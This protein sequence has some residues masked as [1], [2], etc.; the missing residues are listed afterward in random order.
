MT[1]QPRNLRQI[2]QKR[3]ERGM[4]FQDSG[5]LKEALKV[6]KW[7]LTQDPGD[8]DVL[9]NAGV[10][11]GQLEPNGPGYFKAAEYL[12]KVVYSKRSSPEKKA[13][14]LNQLG[15]FADRV[16]RPD[17]ALPAYQMAVGICPHHVP[18]RNNYASQL[19][20]ENR[21]QEAQAEFDKALAI[22]PDSADAR[23]NSAFLALTTGQYERG[24][25]EFAWR[26]K[27]PSHTS[28]PFKSMTGKP[29]W[30]GEDLNGKTL[31]VI[32]EQGFGDTFMMVRFLRVIKERW[33]GCR[34]EFFGSPALE[35]VLVC[36]CPYLDGYITKGT[37]ES[38]DCWAHT[39]TLPAC[40]GTTYETVPSEVPY[41][42]HLSNVFDGHITKEGLRI[43]IAWAGSPKHGR[44][45]LRSLA[46][47][48][49]QP[50]VDS[51]PDAHWY[52][53][54]VGPR[55]DEVSRLRGV[56]D[57]APSIGDWVN[58][59]G[60]LSQLDLLISCDTGTV[61]LAGAMGLPV[62]MLCPHSADWR[63]GMDGETSVWYPRLTIFRQPQRH[64]W[65]T[66]VNQVIERLKGWAP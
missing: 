37:E 6:W 51:R 11:V 48:D 44:D 43:G 66:P 58:T 3:L 21:I 54:Q 9:F 34:I 12:E 23:L 5:N 45:A 41:L 1:V 40:L 60:A 30:Q 19:R 8:P 62:F 33:P 14:A 38:F 36:G 22:D 15:I 53:L 35:K 47:E 42:L 55:C 56:T 59:A 65:K 29:E 50:I 2:H 39:F 26:W 18:A 57:L 13:D 31:L 32:E 28:K 24:F 64:D 49:M 46:P 52:S 20:L 4:R 16:G 17:M 25:K 7:Y 10:I 27:C 63:W 61:H